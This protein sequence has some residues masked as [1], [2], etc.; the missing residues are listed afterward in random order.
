MIKLTDWLRDEL[1]RRRS[2]EAPEECCGLI[3][4]YTDGEASGVSLWAAE[5]VAADPTNAFEIGAENLRRILHQIEARNE[6]L[7]GVY[8]SHKD[9]PRPSPADVEA[10]ARWPGL[11]WVIVGAGA[12]IDC[13]D[14]AECCGQV[15]DTGE[16]CAALYGTD[17][18]VPCRACGGSQVAPDYWVGVLA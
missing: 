3:S 8:H 17:R 4:R 5:N 18:L 6:V 7:A 2:Q 9:S 14:G 16:C 1:W 13:E 11:T 15:L 12:C 10:A